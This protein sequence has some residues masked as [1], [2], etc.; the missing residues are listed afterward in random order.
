MCSSEY[1]HFTKPQLSPYWFWYGLRLSFLVKMVV[2]LRIFSALQSSLFISMR[3]ITWLNSQQ[4]KTRGH[5]KY[6]NKV[7]CRNI[8][9]W[10]NIV[11][12]F[13][14]NDWVDHTKTFRCYGKWYFV[15]KIVV[16]I[17]K[18]FWNLRLK[19]KNLQNF[20]DH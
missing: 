8:T 13:H 1:L 17:E 7:C 5:V 3:K 9:I 2:I 16:V 10:T 20:W 19:A 18:A 11:H 4:T 6:L 14:L 15:T 12:C